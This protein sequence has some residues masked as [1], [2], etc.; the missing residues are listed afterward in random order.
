MI[1]GGRQR[2]MGALRHHAYATCDIIQRRPVVDDEVLGLDRA[3]HTCR[4]TG[5]CSGGDQDR[6]DDDPLLHTVPLCGPETVSDGVRRAS[7]VDSP[8]M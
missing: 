4:I 7:G 8:N 5:V 2:A 6:G 1:E 3:P